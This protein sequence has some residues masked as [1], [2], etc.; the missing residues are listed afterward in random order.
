MATPRLD[1]LVSRT[2][3]MFLGNEAGEVQI[4]DDPVLKYLSEQSADF[5]AR[6]VIGLYAEKCV[7]HENSMTDNE[8]RSIAAKLQIP[9]QYVA[10][11][12]GYIAS[13][14]GPLWAHLDELLEGLPASHL[15]ELFI[16]LH[17][18]DDEEFPLPDP[19]ASC[20]SEYLEDLVD[21][22]VIARL[23]RS[24]GGELLTFWLTVTPRS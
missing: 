4:P 5:I 7:R 24:C 15:G 23:I 22:A 6:L 14:Y 1:E 21:E 13:M 19:I 8:V 17:S 11:L 20:V 2:K 16:E 18:S 10:S 12:A 9:S 3:A